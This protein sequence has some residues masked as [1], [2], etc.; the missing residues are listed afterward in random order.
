VADLTWATFAA[1]VRPLPDALCPMPAQTRAMYELP[2]PVVNAVLDP[3]LLAH[4]DFIYERHLVL[5][6]DF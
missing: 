5:P 2:H 1:L 4:R 6:L 3:A